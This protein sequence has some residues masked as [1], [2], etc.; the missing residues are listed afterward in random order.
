[1]KLLVGLFVRQLSIGLIVILKIVCDAWDYP[2]T[3]GIVAYSM[4]IMYDR[5]R[6]CGSSVRKAIILAVYVAVFRYLGVTRTGMRSC[7]RRGRWNG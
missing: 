4:T 1:M 6:D 5:S 3:C 2:G 7:I